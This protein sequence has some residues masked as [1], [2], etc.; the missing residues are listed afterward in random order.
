M[1]KP[2]TTTPNR[3]A[4]EKQ[5]VAQV[6][7]LARRSRK[8][9]VFRDFLRLSAMS[10]SNAFLRNHDVDK[11][12]AD[13]LEKY[14]DRATAERDFSYLLALTVEALELE[15][16]DF[17]GHI[18]MSQ[19]MGISEAGQFFTPSCI[20]RTLATL[21][22]G[23]I[24]AELSGKEYITVNDPACGGGVMLIEAVAECQRQGLNH[25]RQVCFYAEDIDITCVHMT[26]VQLALL[27]VPAIV[28]H[29]NTISMET[30]SRWRTPIWW[31]NGFEYKERRR[32]QAGECITPIAKTRS[33]GDDGAADQQ[34][35]TDTASPAP[36]SHPRRAAAQTFDVDLRQAVQAD[37][38]AG[39]T[40]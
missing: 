38:F 16:S 14:G 8:V 33:A 27:G 20:A 31:L 9:D 37:L 25:S 35:T 12:Y 22:L 29:R 3:I 21:T 6:T 10:I 19:E 34:H 5:F 36:E 7:D 40:A 1:V 32:Q 26:Y 13:L 15:P 17:L 18:Y 30:W 4:I 39:I 28:S 24:K 11:G 2:L 23:D